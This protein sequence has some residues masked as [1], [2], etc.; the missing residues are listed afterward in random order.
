MLEKLALPLLP[1]GDLNIALIAAPRAIVARKPELTLDE[2]ESYYRRL[3]EYLKLS[4]TQAVRIAADEGV[5][6][7]SANV[8]R[9]FLQCSHSMQMRYWSRSRLPEL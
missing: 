8:L 2:L 7:A 9:A 6:N 4:K 3:D 5:E 1:Q